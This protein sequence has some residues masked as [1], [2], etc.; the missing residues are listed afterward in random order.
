MT[1]RWHIDEAPTALQLNEIAK[2]LREGSV[3]LMPTDTIYGLHAV[4]TNAE[5]V[6]RIAD[7]KGRDETK[8]FI[9]IAS[10]TDQIRELGI[11]T[12]SDLLASLDSIWPA[13]LTAI[14]PLS[15]PTPASRGESTLAVRIPA[16]DWLRDLAA[17]S[18]PL[19]STSANRS[20]EPAVTVP[21]SLPR[22]IGNSG[23]YR[24]RAPLCTGTSSFLYTV[25][26]EI[27]AENAPEIR[28]RPQKI[29]VFPALHMRMCD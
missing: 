14:L 23:P 17:R 2:L 3:V 29:A 19:V 6:E 4:A 10:S 8:P 18:G 26:V 21:D 9:V 28:A 12:S 15:A 27:V 24:R 20:G 25:C 1:R 22:T 16:L 13:P 5:A 7:I 11:S